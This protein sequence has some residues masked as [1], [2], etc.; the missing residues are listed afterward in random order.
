MQTQ[1]DATRDEQLRR[2]I[3]APVAISIHIEIRPQNAGGHDATTTSQLSCKL[4]QDTGIGLGD[5]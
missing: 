4:T 1:D 3:F 2:Y 5:L